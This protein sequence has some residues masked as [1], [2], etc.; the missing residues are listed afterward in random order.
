[1]LLFIL[2]GDIYVEWGVSCLN[3]KMQNYR[4][5]FRYIQPSSLFFNCLIID[6]PPPTVAIPLH[7]E[8]QQKQ[9]DTHTPTHTILPLGCHCVW[10]YKGQQISWPKGMKHFKKK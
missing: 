7:S 9:N 10:Q 5:Q 1:M 6:T 3:M 2:I 8:A 4:F